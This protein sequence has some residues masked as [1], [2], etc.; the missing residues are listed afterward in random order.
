[1]L[2]AGVD[3]HKKYSRVVVTDSR[4]ARVAQ[5]S[6]A[7]DVASFRDFFL[8]LGESATAVLE[9][10]RTWGV[11]YDLLED[12]GIEPVLANPLKTRAIAE[13]KIK[14]DTID[15][16]TLADLLRA[17]LIPTVHVSSRQV[18]AQKNLLR[19]RLW[20]I[21]LRTMVKN[22]IH[23]ILD[24]NHVVM[25]PCSDIFGKA[26]RQLLDQTNLP[27]P[28][29]LLFKAHLE[30]LDYIQTQ[31]SDTEKW[32]KEALHTHP[33]IATLRTIPG[34]GKIF[35]ALVA[36]EI[37][38][39]RR[40]SHPSKLCAYAGLVPTTY[41]SGGKVHHGRLLPN[42]NRWLRWAYVEAAWIAQRTSP[43][44][45]TYF[46]R[47]KRRKGANSASTALARRL[48]EITWYCLTEN[49]PYEELV[50]GREL[51]RL[52]SKVL[53]LNRTS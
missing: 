3:T 53:G 2:Y 17:D 23:H 44:C 47:I 24:R 9:A 19:Q 16:R 28:D 25:P 26:G 30:L 4:G 48:C 15:A 29:N 27:A 35:S 37:D 40:F 32:I 13:A 6:L 45:H 14:T 11:I 5:A 42:C 51:A 52:P 21:G 46:E 41:A 31:V 50:L 1:M 49:R 18:R 8:Q 12:I 10:G 38:D 7:N 20:L 36:L 34:L 39:V 43:Y 22:R 33:G